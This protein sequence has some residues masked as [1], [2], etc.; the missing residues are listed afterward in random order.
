[1][2]DYSKKDIN[3]FKTTDN[4][5]KVH[6]I[7]GVEHIMLINE[8]F[9]NKLKFFENCNWSIDH[10]CVKYTGGHE[11]DEFMCVQLVFLPPEFPGKATCEDHQY[12][13]FDCPRVLSSISISSFCKRF[14]RGK[15]GSK[16]TPLQEMMYQ[17]IV[18]IVLY[19]VFEY[20]KDSLRPAIRGDYHV[21]F[22]NTADTINNYIEETMTEIMKYLNSNN[23]LHTN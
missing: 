18:E 12:M 10:A 5:F 23:K 13:K 19:N 9:T 22:N 11:N 2:T 16:L 15:N 14:E 8:N 7:N 21:E 3:I 20:G 1:M 17:D 4:T 6:D